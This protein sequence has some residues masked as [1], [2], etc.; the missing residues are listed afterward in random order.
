MLTVCNVQNELMGW[1]PFMHIGH[2]HHTRRKIDLRVGQYPDFNAT[3]IE[4]REQM[5]DTMTWADIVDDATW[6]KAY[7]DGF[8][9][10]DPNV[11][12]QYYYADG[13]AT[14]AEKKNGYNHIMREQM[15]RT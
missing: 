12:P 15:D 2:G 3:I 11:M 9:K 5:G 4:L 8:I 6:A 7:E 14:E 13:P 1:T 10:G